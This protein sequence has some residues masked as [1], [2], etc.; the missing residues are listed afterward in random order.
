MGQTY[1]IEARHPSHHEPEQLPAR[2]LVLI[3]SAADGRRVARL[4]LAT[5]QQVAEFD[6]ASTEVLSITQGLRPAH[7][8]AGPDWDRP[9][10]AH[11]AAE[12]EAAE[13]YALDV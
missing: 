3:D 12:R 7:D 5:R 6:A 1:G 11:S 8:A 2:Y 4:Y 9:L 10:S 13:V